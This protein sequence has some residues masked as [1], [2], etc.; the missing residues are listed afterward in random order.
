VPS[1]VRTEHRGRGC[2]AFADGFAIATARDVESADGTIEVELAVGRE[3]SFHGL[4]W[5]LADDANYESF[6]VRP[7]QIGNLDAVQ[8]TPVFNHVS[9]WRCP[10]TSA[11]A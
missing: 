5:H 6:F 7:H 2:T 10:R 8:Y 3:R 11:G 4:V 9:A 1:P